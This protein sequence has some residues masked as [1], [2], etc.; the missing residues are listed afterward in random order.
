MLQVFQLCRCLCDLF[1]TPF[2]IILS[3]LLIVDL[4]IIPVVNDLIPVIDLIHGVFLVLSPGKYLI[5]KAHILS[6]PTVPH[7]PGNHP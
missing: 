1:E 4:K 3:L 5:K 7:L 2:D 6:L